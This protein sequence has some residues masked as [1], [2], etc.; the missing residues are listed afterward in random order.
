MNSDHGAAP[1]PQIVRQ[2]ISWMMRMGNAGASPRVQRQCADW[3]AADQRHELAWQRIQSLN[4]EVASHYRAVPGAGLALEASA[5]RLS[6]RQALKLLGVAGL[7]GSAAWLGG[8]LDQWQQWSSD[9]ATGVGERRSF[10]LPDGSA[11]QLNTRSAADIRFSRQQ[12]LVSLRHGEIMISCKA[13]PRPFQV[14]N[15]DALFET[16]NGRFTVRQQDDC[17]RLSV[18]RGKVAIH[19]PQGG[20]LTWAQ[21]GQSWQVDQAGPR[22]MATPDM[23]MG[24]WADGLIVTRNMRLQPFLEEVNRYRHGYLSCAAGIADLRLSGVFR[25]D[26]TDKLLALLPQALPVRL[27]SRTRFWVRLESLQG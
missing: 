7:L 19:S 5:Q 18:T 21:A 9:Y 8:D 22:L 11:M 24:A 3:R 14:S 27:H 20:S 10:V 15:C 26:D 2:A 1:D 23:D 6:R 13:D 25:L 12:R 16:G 17:T 4:Q